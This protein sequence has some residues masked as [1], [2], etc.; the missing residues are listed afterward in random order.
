M[1]HQQNTI[2]RRARGHKILDSMCATLRSRDNVVRIPSVVNVERDVAIGTQAPCLFEQERAIHFC[3][4]P[5]A[6]SMALSAEWAATPVRL[7]VRLLELA[8]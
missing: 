6:R 8:T 7:P 2:A 3:H 4:S 1:L 5:T